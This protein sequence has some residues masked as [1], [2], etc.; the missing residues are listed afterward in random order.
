MKLR[1]DSLLCGTLVEISDKSII[2]DGDADTIVKRGGSKQVFGPAVGDY[3][4]R[5]D[6]DGIVRM[7]IKK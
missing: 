2:I 3:Y 1:V 6:T 5:C 7:D 4:L